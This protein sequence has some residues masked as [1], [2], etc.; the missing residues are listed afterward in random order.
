MIFSTVSRAIGLFS[1]AFSKLAT[2]FSRSK[3]SRLPSFFTTE[4]PIIS[5]RSYVVSR[6]PQCKH[7]LRRLMAFNSTISRLS[8]TRVLAIKQNG[9]FINDWAYKRK[10]HH[11]LFCSTLSKI[12]PLVHSFFESLKKHYILCL[13]PREKY[14]IR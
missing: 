4:N 14:N 7:S 2:N 12:N 3:L 9:H 11:L 5:I 13:T 8:K 10:L 1:Q 6:F